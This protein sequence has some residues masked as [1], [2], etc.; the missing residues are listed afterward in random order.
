MPVLFDAVEPTLS[1]ASNRPIRW[2]RSVPFDGIEQNGAKG[3]YTLKEY[4]Y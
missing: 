4:I 2:R 1:M 3:G